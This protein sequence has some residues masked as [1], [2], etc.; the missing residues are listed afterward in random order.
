MQTVGLETNWSK[1]ERIPHRN[2]VCSNACLTGKPKKQAATT[3]GDGFKYRITKEEVEIQLMYMDKK[4]QN[5]Q[6]KGTMRPKEP[7]LTCRNTSL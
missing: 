5:E 2:M 3:E 1:Q 6:A 4:R 7:Q